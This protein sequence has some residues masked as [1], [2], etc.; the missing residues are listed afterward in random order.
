[1]RRAGLSAPRPGWPRFLLRLGLA[2]A[3]MLTALLAARAVVGAWPELA[4]AQR[5]VHLAWTIG[6]GGLAYA[7]ALVGL[8]LRPKD[9]RES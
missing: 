4:P 9:L 1:V 2:C 5:I 6:L 7:A 8:G 3:A